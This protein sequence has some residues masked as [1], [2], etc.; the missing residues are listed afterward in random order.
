MQLSPSDGYWNDVEC[1]LTNHFICQFR[2][3]EDVDEDGDEGYDDAT[4]AQDE[5]KIV[6]RIQVKLGPKYVPTSETETT[7]E[8]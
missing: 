1:T 2:D 7:E 6:Q 5:E 8:D 3:E 4:V